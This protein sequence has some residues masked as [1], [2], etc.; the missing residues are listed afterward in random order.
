VD[1]LT[2]VPRRA[3]RRSRRGGFT[4]VEVLV[5]FTILGVGLL[6]LAAMQLHALRFGRSG[7]HTSD[8]AVVA[9]N[10]MERLQGLPW[11]HADLNPT[12]A[13]VV[14]PDVDLDVDSAAGTVTEQSYALRRRVTNLIPNRTR[15]VDVR[16]QWSEPERPNRSFT[17]TSVLVNTGS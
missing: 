8:A 15:S 7:R 13:W 5:A 6:A 17:L 9:R 12:G 2:R 4:L 14:L 1:Q 11:A 10:E 3:P 16:V